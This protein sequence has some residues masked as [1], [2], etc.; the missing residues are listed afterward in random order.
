MAQKEDIVRQRNEN[1]SNI[2]EKLIAENYEEKI[3]T[4]SI[5]KANIMAFLT[6]GPFAA[7]F[8]VLFA[9]FAPEKDWS[10][11]LQFFLVLAVCVVSIAVHELLHGAGWVLF[12]K[13]K[14]KSINFGVMWK[15]LTPYCHCSEPLTVAQYYVG[16]LMPFLILGIIP[17]AISVFTGNVVLLFYGTLFILCAGGDTTVGFI[18]TKFIGKNAVILDHPS[19]CGFVAFVKKF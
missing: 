14:H 17:S 6:A 2:R 5:P 19:E 7:L 9:F 15:Y 3:C 1:Y 8:I 13:N 18:M 10:G 11:F 4:I 16:L 12:C